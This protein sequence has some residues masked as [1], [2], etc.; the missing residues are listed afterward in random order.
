MDI[1]TLGTYSV[2][3]NT[4]LHGMV[5]QANYKY[6]TVYMA[7]F[8]KVGNADSDALRNTVGY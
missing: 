8:Y 5:N 4:E 1:Q 7:M 3:E 6:P 2:S